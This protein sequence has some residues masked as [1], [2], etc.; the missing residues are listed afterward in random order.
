MT[1][2]P[3]DAAVVEAFLVA[4][5]PVNIRVATQVMNQIEQ[6][7]VGQRRQREMQLEQARY[8]A[9][10]AQR[11]YDAVDPSNRLVAAELE[12]RWNEKLERVT[13]LERAFAQAERDAEWKLTA[14]ERVAITDLSRDLPAIWSAETTSNQERKQ[15]L[16]MAIESVQVDGRSQLGQIEV[17]IRW[18][19]G[20]ITSLNVKRA[21][22][23][24]S[25]LKT[26]AEAVS[27]I[28][29]LTPRRTYAEIAT[30]LN[31][32]GLR[33]AFGR[34]FT[35]QHVGYICRRDG[36][37]GRKPRSSSN[38]TPESGGQVES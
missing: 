34:R 26:P 22:P 11:Q 17:Q 4:I 7:L 36:L 27:R 14:E 21:A 38:E 19:S 33:S 24:E 25:S 12:R 3:I 35:S 20:T 18:R 32:A 30:A 9:R 1:S 13:E 5:S 23:G 31:R 29:K 16:R 2:R 8:E 15:L 6:E 28:H 37:G 10:L